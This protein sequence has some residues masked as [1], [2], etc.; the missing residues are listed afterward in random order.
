MIEKF[1]AEEERR[2]CLTLEERGAEDG[3]EVQRQLEREPA[4]TILL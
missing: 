4:M 3:Q 2:S 1:C